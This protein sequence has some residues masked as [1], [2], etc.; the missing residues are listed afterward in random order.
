[1][2]WDVLV[3]NAGGQPVPELAADFEAPP[4]GT[5]DHVRGE[6]DRLLGPVDWS[7][8]VWGNATVAGAGVEFN[9][10]TDDPVTSVMLHIRGGGDVVPVLIEFSRQSGWALLDCGSGEWLT[11]AADAGWDDWQAYRDL[12]IRESD[13]SPQAV[14]VLGGVWPVGTR[15]VVQLPS[16]RFVRG[17]ALGLGP[18]QSPADFGV[19]LGA[20]AP[21]ISWDHSWVRCLDFGV[22]DADALR[23]ALVDALERAGTQRVEIACRGG[24][25]R[26][27]LALAC[28][29]ILDGL[30]AADA[31]AYVRSQYKPDA[32]ETSRQ[33]R[34]V[35]RF[36]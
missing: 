4:L 9:L 22:P 25:G 6:F 14:P 26:T 32:V 35:E 1:M 2:S 34:F 28:L 18:P 7:D 21:K 24:V 13:A 5:G 36:R 19:Y 33:R 27:G 15:G 30:P 31:V 29:A 10:G 17:R 3:V 12:V 20:W 8:P 16:R 11:S 23:A